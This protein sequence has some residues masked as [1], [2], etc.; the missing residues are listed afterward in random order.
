MRAY[1]VVVSAFALILLLHDGEKN[2]RNVRFPGGWFS[3]IAMATPQPR[4]L[5]ELGVA[6]V[7]GVAGVKGRLKFARVSS[8]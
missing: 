4:L 7:T 8:L 6:D 2:R 3:T 1:G 5:Q